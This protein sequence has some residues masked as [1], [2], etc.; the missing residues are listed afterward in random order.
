MENSFT[1]VTIDITEFEDSFWFATSEKGDTLNEDD[2]LERGRS[3]GRRRRKRHFFMIFLVSSK[4]LKI[5]SLMKKTLEH[6]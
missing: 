3:E 5:V 2:F 6:S 1:K 4:G